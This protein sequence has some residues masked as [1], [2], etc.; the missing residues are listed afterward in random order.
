MNLSRSRRRVRRRNRR[1]NGME[2]LENRLLLAE[3][4]WT[5]AGD[6]ESWSNANNWI[7]EGEAGLP[8]DGD[9]VLIPGGTLTVSFESGSV[10]L[11]S[12]ASDASL[13]I[14]GGSLTVAN[15]SQVDGLLTLTG[16]TLTANGE[17]QLAD[18][19]EWTGGRLNGTNAITLSASTEMRM[20]SD[21]GRGIGNV[22]I[23]GDGAV[24]WTDGFLQST[25]GIAQPTFDVPD[26][27]IGGETEKR[28]LGVVLHNTAEMTITGEG[29]LLSRNFAGA[30]RG[31]GIVNEADGRLRVE[32]DF[33]LASETTPPVLENFGTVEV[34]DGDFSISGSTV[35]H[36][37]S[38]L[39]GSVTLAE[40]TNTIAG[41]GFVADA[42]R[43][44]SGTLQVGGNWSVAERLDWDGG[45][46][47]GAGQTTLPAGSQLNIDGSAGRGIG[48][49]T[50]SGQGTI[51]WTA[52]FLQSTSGIVRPVFDV[53]DFSISGP[54]E[55]R[56]LGVVLR[57]TGGMTLGDFGLLVSR[58]F[59]GVNAGSG[60][61]NEPGGTVRVTGDFVL[62]S[63]TNPAVFENFGAVE[64]D[65]GTFRILGNSNWH[66]SSSSSGAGRISLESSFL[67]GTARIIGPGFSAE[68]IQISGG[69]LEIG[70]DWTVTGDFDW[71]GGIL[72]GDGK[73][74][75]SETGAFNI[76]GAGGRLGDIVVDGHGMVN[77]TDGTIQPLSSTTSSSPL[78]D[79][80]LN[81]NGPEDKSITD[82]VLNTSGQTTLGGTGALVINNTVG[83]AAAPGIQN[84]ADGVFEVKDGATIQQAGF[85][86]TEFRNEGTYRQLTEQS[87]P[88]GVG[89]A[90]HSTGTVQVP[91]GQVDALSLD[92]GSDRYPLVRPSATLAVSGDVTGATR[93]S[94][95]Y[96]ATGRLLLNGNSQSLEVMG[97][98]RGPVAAGFLE[99]FV[100]GL[101]ELNSTSVTLVDQSDNSAGN[102]E[103]LYV[104]TLVVPANSELDLAG[105][106]LYARSAL[107]EGT[108]SGGAVTIVDMPGVLPFNTPTSG[109]IQ[110]IGEVDEWTFDGIVGQQ[111][112]II[113]DPGD[114]IS[115]LPFAPTLGQVRVE[116]VSP[117]G[118]VISA[119][120]NSAANE[121]ARMN[122]IRLAESGIYRVR[123][124]AASSTPDG[125]GNYRITLADASL[126]IAPLVF[127]TRELGE[128]ES[129]YSVD[130]W[131]FSGTTNQ[132]IEFDFLN[133]TFAGI[134]FTLSGPDGWVG[135]ENESGDVP[136]LTLPADGSYV[137]SVDS[138]GQGTGVY[139]FRLNSATDIPLTLGVAESGE[140]TG[141]GSAH[142]YSVEIVEPNPLGIRF[143]NSSDQ[144]R[145]EIYVKRGAAPT[146][147]DFDYRSTEVA[148]DQ[149][150]LVPLA[151]SG[152]WFI[153]AYGERVE[154]PS[155]F[156]IRATADSAFVNGVVPMEAPAQLDVELTVLGVGFLPGSEVELV[157]GDGAVLSA[158]TVVVNS[159]DEITATFD[160]SS[161]AEQVYDVRVILPD[162]DPLVLE[163]SFE[164]TT[165][166]EG[167]FEASLSVPPV[168]GRVA[169]D[170]LFVEYTNT[171]TAPL[172]APIL[173][174]RPFDPDG[175]D[176]PLLTLDESRWV[177]G[178]W[179]N[180]TSA[181][182]DGFQTSLQ[183]Y[184]QG[185][186]PGILRPGER[187]EVPI[188]F[189]GLHDPDIDDVVL[190]LELVTFAAGDPTPVD[191]DGYLESARSE[192][193]EPAA[194]DAV[195]SN[196]VD[197]IGPSWGDYIEMLST[198][199]RYLHGLGKEVRDVGKLFDITYAAANGFSSLAALVN[200]L[201]A[202]DT[203]PGLPLRYTRSFG[204]SITDRYAMGPF[205]RGWVASSQP[206]LVVADD[207]TVVFSENSESVRR[208]QPDIRQLGRFLASPSETGTL[209]RVDGGDFELTETDGLYRRFDGD[210]KPLFVHDT[211]GNR[212]TYFY[213]GEQLQAITHSAGAELTFTYSPGGLVESITDSTGWTTTY[214]YNSAGTLLESV[215]D[216]RGTTRYTYVTG[217]G[218]A[219]EFALASVEGPSGVM[220]HFEYDAHGRL[221]STYLSGEANRLD[222]QY[223]RPGTITRVD[224]SG[225][226]EHLSFDEAGRPARTEDAADNYQLFT[227]DVEG[228]LVRVQDALGREQE[229]EWSTNGGLRSIRDQLG[230]QIL[231]ET[232]GPN[233]QP[234]SF[235]DGNGNVHDFSYDGRGN[236][237]SQTFPDGSVE[238]ASYD[239]AGN[240][241]SL[242][243][244]RNETTELR[245]NAAG[246]VV[247]ERFPDGRTV[248][249]S[250]D[251]LDRLISVDDGGQV[252]RYEYYS[253]DRLQRISP[254]NGRWLEYEYNARGQLTELQDH[255][256]FTVRYLYDTAGRLQELRDGTGRS[257][258]TYEY[259]ATGNLASEIKANG[260]NT[261]YEYDSVGR[262]ATV[263]H[264]RAD[265][266][267]NSRFQ[268]GYDILGRRTTMTSHD[269]TWSYTYDGRGQLTRAA[270]QST[271]EE[272]DD[273][274]LSYFYDPSGNRLQTVDSGV[275]TTW[276]VNELNQLTSSS[277]ATTYEY[278]LD[279][280]LV[281]KQTST[282]VWTY[283]YD[284][285]NL[286]TNAQG[287]AGTWQYEYDV[288]GNRIAA[289]RDGIRTE[290]LLD[291][292][293]LVD[294]VGT[295]D[296]AGS[297][298]QS[299]VH[300]F[301]LEA[302]ASASDWHYYDFD[303]LGSTA[304]LSG[305]D[306]SYV[307]SYAYT[308][309]GRSLLAEETIANAF[310]YVGQS[311]VMNEDNGLLFMR[312]RYYSP[313]E[314]RFQSIDPLQILDFNFYAYAD[315][316][317]TELTDPLGLQSTGGNTSCSCT[318][319]PFTGVCESNKKRKPD[320]K[321][322]PTEND[323]RSDPEEEEIVTPPTEVSGPWLTDPSTTGLA[324][325]GAARAGSSFSLAGSGNACTPPQTDD[326]ETGTNGTN[327][328]ETPRDG[329][330]RVG[331]RQSPATIG[332]RD[333]NEKLVAGGFGPSGF[334]TPDA[335][336][337]Y[338]I[339]FENLGPGSE[340]EPEN[341][342][343]APAQRVVITDQLSTDLDWDSLRF[344][345][346][347]FGDT[348][349][350]FEEAGQYHFR[351]LPITIDEESF[352]LE[353]E[354]SFNSTS[355]V[356]RAVF[357]SIRP[358]TELPPSV[359]TGFLPPEDG[360][361]IGQ[362]FI[363]FVIQPVQGL[364]TGVEIRNVAEIS[365]D[366]Q[367][368]IATNQVNPEDPSE[369]T[370]PELEALVTIDAGI[371][372][373]AV[374]ALPAVTEVS[375]F[376]VAWS[377]QD[378]VGGSGVGSYDVY[379]AVDDGPFEL[380]LS[381][382]TETSAEFPGEH[383]R[384]YAFYSVARD[385]VGNQEAPAVGADTFTTVLLPRLGVE[386]WAATSTGFVA[387]FSN[388][389]DLSVLNLIDTGAA[390]HGTP[391]VMLVGDTTGPISGSLVVSETRR[392]VT[393][394]AT[395]G[396]LPTDNYTLTLR[397]AAD[398]FRDTSGN[399]LDGDGDGAAGGDF[400]ET[401]SSTSTGVELS[402]PN[403]V[404]GP[405]QEINLPADTTQ[406]IPIS[407][408]D[409]TGIRRATFSIDFNGN[410]LNIT[411]A[412][413]GGNLPAGAAVSIDTST[414][415]LAI[416]DVT[417]PTDLP[418]SEYPL[419]HLVATVPAATAS[420]Q[421]G[422]Q[423]VLDI[424]GIQL[425]DSAGSEV[426]AIDSDGV[427]VVAF[428]GD[429]S[430]NQRVNA[431]DAS[432]LARVAALLDAGFDS[433]PL[434]DPRMVGDISGNRIVNAADA[435]LIARFAALFPVRQIP[436]LPTATQAATGGVPLLLDKR[437]QP[438]TSL[439]KSEL[440]DIATIS[441][442]AFWRRFGA[443]RV[444]TDFLEPAYET[445]VGSDGIE[446]PSELRDAIDELF[447]DLDE[448]ELLDK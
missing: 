323:D 114:G 295:Y 183:I 195:V 445:G 394:V 139:A 427:H 326:S 56:L 21:G 138:A 84:L 158:Q 238:R 387:E 118:A 348:V 48:E 407:I 333:P 35:W 32:G 393:F 339:K 170:T 30:S 252:T 385:N 19:F 51:N 58:N 150:L 296:S 169:P 234:L 404:R 45:S 117:S 22:T 292:T 353:V 154:T 401:F 286:L 197:L 97:E 70:G 115:F 395:A 122:G 289:T 276:Q 83:P 313:D 72:L 36:G 247:E 363:G 419:V 364:A 343:T 337:P 437:A 159:F 412:V 352:D 227:Y 43:L 153:L 420:P 228:N 321:P 85:A 330:S 310:E 369:G 101:L 315:N 189:S 444:S 428:L 380:W 71:T 132:V 63:D 417:S 440:I 259:D 5:G 241:R 100:V 62:Q 432:Q 350:T 325:A 376:E 133:A 233:G 442:D 318:P 232:G 390:E 411:D 285:R 314:A 7:R 279:G 264:R 75:L 421:Y 263:V 358:G 284:S 204:T 403:F 52:G 354:L 125:T 320:P 311:G 281:R 268:Y 443:V 381:R 245:Y 192:F 215:T 415:N 174:L 144:D 105:L 368:I 147:R 270:F 216:P 162:I 253:D 365:F 265:G 433:L 246:Q 255:S 8:Q 434:T 103:A 127:N 438:A 182:P 297:R 272:I 406:G 319:S 351:N 283:E 373:S 308:P 293:G 11:N 142:L 206:R 102:V 12:L 76:N 179:I 231:F 316:Q 211:N 119:G 4:T 33:Q 184:A 98:D 361:G 141:H 3:V 409:G 168:L 143:E 261:T 223:D 372:S 414:P 187:V 93:E 88:F 17:I 16:G 336:I 156:T 135:F 181:F 108:V 294:V 27:R 248:E 41:D 258:V 410:L 145:V 24:I 113:A 391:D 165:A 69:T 262:V 90:F 374:T 426:A 146:R 80:T 81:I 324:L 221:E 307:N 121:V 408:A 29:G 2:L 25:S 178:V 193:V 176:R 73:T 266:T 6:G 78:F 208:F 356:L 131:T 282:G 218:A 191:W 340:P 177:N 160:L 424:H 304:G 203:A 237:L 28:L 163:D 436:P 89:V 273:Q 269:G 396:R 389:L 148:A 109:T 342:A 110:A 53:A 26:F 171:G 77:W 107:L 120:E 175:S 298:V 92:F 306:G 362:G 123:V 214:A 44:S 112:S 367:M 14:D 217:Q 49:V 57:N 202:E 332:S 136:L 222:F 377:G 413:L 13:T 166:G 213:A 65:T 42:L 399:A 291:P 302:T 18:D 448:V 199:A 39:S 344:T 59:A 152:R 290:Y 86:S 335:N 50:F 388:E 128:I 305:S 382:T 429:V 287:P 236:R 130:Q 260:T 331:D 275:S 79:V 378:D 370:D 400:V 242:T 355:G 430:G 91:L 360:T 37:G 347:G 194:W 338:T 278:D 9:D 55:K 405:G 207:G 155:P 371:P 185:E 164:V 280:N 87:P 1:L 104:D 423:H 327:G 173:V 422:E 38:L 10:S 220:R 82:L 346:F 309:F 341:P 129:L 124:A 416:V 359:L 447:R 210:G 186:R 151:T 161:A 418:A 224:G 392:S 157:A 111:I 229:L 74:T 225:I 134:G 116:L 94:A 66:G 190:E 226:I 288:F 322:D 277:A 425:L 20:T 274:D 256:G 200:E 431:A 303:A 68:N 301:G 244:R 357:Q 172:L 23:Q 329:G 402:V 379:I 446:N 239:A 126:D 345:E 34:N 230:N 235:T 209:V 240:P 366:N 180:G 198:N 267:E 212:L 254:P 383:N 140:L 15:T 196:L 54:A 47:V 349:V 31:S 312:A 188:Y 435:S 167:V 40:G 96:D 317:P 386:N 384:S 271:N 99:N 257:I 398:G 106:N 201:D 95:N 334:I 67:T 61:V 251:A 375:P 205:G 64:L 149:S 439:R 249:Y 243:N 250:Y 300:G 219:Q 328:P 441:F 137:L 46:I 299:F 397:G 60:I